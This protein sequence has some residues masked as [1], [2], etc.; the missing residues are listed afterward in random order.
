MKARKYGVL[1]PHEKALGILSILM[2]IGWVFAL[3]ASGGAETETEAFPWFDVL[4]IV[5]CFAVV[6]MLMLKLN[7]IEFVPASVR[8][9]VIATATLLPALGFLIQELTGLVALFTIG[10]AIVLAYV[11]VTFCWRQVFE[12]RSAASSPAA[13]ASPSPPS[14]DS[15]EAENKAEAATRMESQPAT[16]THP[17]APVPEKPDAPSRPPDS[18]VEKAPRS[19]GTSGEPQAE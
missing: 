19:S 8:D 10:G 3:F 6:A 11:S 9:S 18:G 4:S 1:A 17:A 5:G 13:P 7:C 12:Q 14:S 16:Q 15:T 2:L